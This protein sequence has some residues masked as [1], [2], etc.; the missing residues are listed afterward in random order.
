MVEPLFLRF[1]LCFWGCLI[2]IQYT[3]AYTALSEESLRALPDPGNDFDIT[4]G[5]IL[6]PILR[7]R[8]SG[9]DGSTYVR[10]HIV[11]FF[12]TSLPKW[13]ISFQNS[14]SKTPATG[15]Q[16][17]PFVNIIATRDPPWTIP[18]EVSRLALVAHYDSKLTP[19]GFIGATDSAA[20]CAMIMHVARSIDEGLTKKWEKIQ[21]EGLGLEGEGIEDHQGVQILFLDGEEAFVSWTAT[22][23]LYGARSLA[24][25]WETSVHPAL[26]TY[27]TP[28]SS[29]SLFVLLDLLGAKGPS[30]PSYFKT[31]HW[32]YKNMAYLESRLRS[33]KLFESSPNYPRGNSPSVEKSYKKSTKN[34]PEAR[35]REPAFLTEMDKKDGD[36]WL[37]G[38]IED[39]HLPFMDRGV[40]ILHLIPTPFPR[41][42]HEMTDDGDHLDP[43]TVSD[44]AKLTLA[45]VGE[46]MD[47]EGFL[48][49]R[50]IRS[51][52]QEKKR[53]TRKME[54]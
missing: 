15:N 37:G 11:D 29:I 17:I 40:E 45:F 34:S 9:S 3:A 24:A 1:F 28:L 51:S 10:N 26:S 4:S 31:T 50:A 8:V 27:H 54:L 5:A 30:V 21:T 25:D 38:L 13:D 33:L 41:V 46:W 18:G 42:W 49:K 39:D 36:R 52:Q 48:E 7:P 12:K 22:D 20:P 43:A 19:S 6:S 53:D 32:A 2:G 23:S 16:D 44:W 14:T 47:L 35:W